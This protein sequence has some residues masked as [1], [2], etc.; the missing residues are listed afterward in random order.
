MQINQTQECASAD[1]IRLFLSCHQAKQGC[2]LHTV[3]EVRGGMQCNDPLYQ[4]QLIEIGTRHER[5]QLEKS[6]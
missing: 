3:Q 6:Y 4:F 5:D 1:V 2:L